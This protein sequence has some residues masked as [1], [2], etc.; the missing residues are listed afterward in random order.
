M[1][2]GWD[3]DY[4]STSEQNVLDD[5]KEKFKST[6][7]S[8]I[9]SAIPVILG[10]SFKNNNTDP[11]Y[12]HH[13]IQII[14]G[15][16]RDY[17]VYDDSGILGEVLLGH[18]DFVFILTWKQLEKVMQYGDYIIYPQ[19]EKVYMGYNDIKKYLCDYQAELLTNTDTEFMSKFGKLG[20]LPSFESAR[21]LIAD[22]VD[23]KFFYMDKKK[24][25]NCLNNM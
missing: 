6:I 25:Q 14:G 24:K 11:D 22:N 2:V 19:Y 16:D 21:C 15:K 23:V 12:V 10:I 5:L 13:A 3:R 8:W 17:V 4:E 20:K 18:R 9:E 7:D 1:F